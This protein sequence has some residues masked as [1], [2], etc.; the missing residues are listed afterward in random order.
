VQRIAELERRFSKALADFRTYGELLKIC[1]LSLRRSNLR[2]GSLTKLDKSHPD[3]FHSPDASVPP[4]DLSLA[5]VQ[6]IVLSAASLYPATQSALTA[7][8]DSPIPDPKESA[9]LIALSERM[10][11]IEATQIAQAVEMAELRKRSEVMIRS[12][13]EGGVLNTSQS[14]ADVESRVEK[15]ERRIRRAE[16]QKE[17]ESAL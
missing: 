3:W 4:S 11:A 8:Q 6:A 1:K 14:L 12:W 17:E 7:V 15:A 16:H 5:E 10:K 9:N 2:H 13:Y